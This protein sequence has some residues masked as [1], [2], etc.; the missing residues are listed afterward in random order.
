MCFL[1]YYLGVWNTGGSV[2]RWPVWFFRW[3]RADRTGLSMTPAWCHWY[4]NCHSSSSRP[5][6]VLRTSRSSVNVQ[7]LLECSRMFYEEVWKGFIEQCHVVTGVRVCMTDFFFC[8]CLK[9]VST[10]TPRYSHISP[11]FFHV[12]REVLSGRFGCVVDICAR[13]W[14]MYIYISWV[15]VGRQIIFFLVCHGCVWA[16]KES[17]F[18][19]CFLSCSCLWVWL[20]RI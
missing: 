10:P 13:R 9:C 16:G 1:I 19:V 18:L 11:F 3:T 5:V 15:H 8:W 12:F 7:A 20:W 2:E 17:F 14:Y 6:Y 4:F